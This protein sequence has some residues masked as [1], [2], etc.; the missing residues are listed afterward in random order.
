MNRR[1]FMGLF[2]G[3]RL[4]VESFGGLQKSFIVY[5]GWAENIP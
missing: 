5:G 3:A 2:P 1:E 4:H